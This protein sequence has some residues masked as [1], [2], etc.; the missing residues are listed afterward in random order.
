VRELR[1]VLQRAA[2]LSTN[3]IIS[4]AEIHTDSAIESSPAEGAQHFVGTH[5]PEPSI[6][7][8][9]SRYIA[10]LLAEHQGKRAHVARILGISE[11]T[12]YRKLKQYGLQSIGRPDAS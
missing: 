4:A 3:G 5:K 11:R 8:L 10:E 6:R 9:E 2:A 12:L 7:G 1:N